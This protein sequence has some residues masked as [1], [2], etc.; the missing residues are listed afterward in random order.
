M[1][2]RRDPLAGLDAEAVARDGRRWEALLAAAEAAGGKVHP[3][4]LYG[5]LRGLRACGAALV[6]AAAGWRLDPPPD[7]TRDELRA[8]VGSH[9]PMLAELLRQARE[10]GQLRQAA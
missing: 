7:M 9:A 3:L 6:P 4:C 2:K 5:L 10:P 1:V 8:E